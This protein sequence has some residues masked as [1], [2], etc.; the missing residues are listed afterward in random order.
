MGP[1]FPWFQE[2]IA[3]EKTDSCVVPESYV[4]MIV[5]YFHAF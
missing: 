3:N 5:S 2:K 4:E 1:L